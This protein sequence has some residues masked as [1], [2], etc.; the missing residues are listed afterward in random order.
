MTESIYELRYHLDGKSTPFYVGR[1]KNI[2]NRFAQHK[3]DSKTKNSPVYQFIRDLDI[4]HVPWDIYEVEIFEEYANQEFIHM[5]KLLDEG[6]KLE[7]EKVGD[8]KRLFTPA[9]RKRKVKP[10]AQPLSAEDEDIRRLAKQFVNSLTS[11]TI[12]VK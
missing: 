10:V 4:A 3:R 2:K 12:K 9:K 5:R 1:T 11:S 6:H 8:L 7:N